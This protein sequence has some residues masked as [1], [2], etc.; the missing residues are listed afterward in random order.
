MLVFV[1][2]FND[3]L[4]VQGRNMRGTPRS[5]PA[6]SPRNDPPDASASSRVRGLFHSLTFVP[7]VEAAMM[8][9]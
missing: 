7:S 4:L 5:L 9:E 1:E 6:C 3:G 2:V 8:R